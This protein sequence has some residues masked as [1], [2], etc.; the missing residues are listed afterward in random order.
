MHRRSIDIAILPPLPLYQILGTRTAKRRTATAF[1]LVFDFF[2]LQ[3]DAPLNVQELN[4]HVMPHV[5][6]V[7][8]CLNQGHVSDIDHVLNEIEEKKKNNH[9]H[10]R[11]ADAG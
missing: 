6:A 1:V 5:A 4:R 7:L 10:H 8:K 9:P 11:T 3:V 2:H